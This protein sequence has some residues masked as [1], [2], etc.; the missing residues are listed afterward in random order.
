MIA[1]RPVK[2]GKGGANIP[3]AVVDTALYR[4][5]DGFGVAWRGEGE[6]G[7]PTLHVERYGPSERKAFRKSLRR[8]DSM[9]VEYVAHFRFA[10]HG[11]KDSPHA[12]PYE[13]EDARE[14]RVLVFHNGIIDIATTK[15][16]SD[17]EVFVRDVLA[18]LPSRWW[19][20]G[21]LKYL[22]GQS[23][24]WSRLVIMTATETVNLQEDDGEWDG[25]L[26]YSSSH[27]PSGY[28]SYTSTGKE[29]GTPAHW[30]GKGYGM[31][32]DDYSD[33]KAEESYS[34]FIRRKAEEQK[35][36]RENPDL[37]ESVSADNSARRS[38]LTLLGETT[39][40]RLLPPGAESMHRNID[41][42]RTFRHGGHTVQAI[43]DIDS[44]NDGDYP[45]SVLCDSC[46][47]VGD[48]Y[49]IDGQA[50]I[51]MAHRTASGELDD[52]LN[53][54]E[55]EDLLP[56]DAER[57]TGTRV[58]GRRAHKARVRVVA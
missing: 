3:H 53:E 46:Y 13:Y 39:E 56:T 17:T 18:R 54:D 8:I 19:H 7:K 9:K 43:V 6:D 52:N 11:P 37:R 47:T 25:G 10:T 32:S 24:G 44:D 38:A 15:A 5:P 4:H 23:I 1:F 50:L 14:G 31:T 51:D 16:E 55:M 40:V 26:W 49:M 20:N 42:P 36:A 21:A 22:V 58:R 41:D 48:L 57:R 33:W 29:Y 12:H 30:S 35:A 27:R 45:S 28:A 34:S 2:P